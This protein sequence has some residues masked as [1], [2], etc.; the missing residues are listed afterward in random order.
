MFEACVFFS[1]F[2]SR[3]RVIGP[4][5]DYQLP[6][7]LSERC[8][9]L[10]HPDQTDCAPGEFVLY[11]M[12][13]AIRGHENPALD[14]AI[15]LA[16]QN[17]LPLVVYHGLSEKYPFASDRHHAFIMQAARDV[18]RELADLGITYAFH[19]ERAGH[20]GPHLRDLTRRA[21]VLV[22]EAM[23][24]APLVAWTERLKSLVS[25]PIVSVDTNCLLSIAQV[26]HL[27]AI[28]PSD[29][30][31][32]QHEWFCQASRY[33]QITQEQYRLR[34]GWDYGTLVGENP[35][36]DVQERATLRFDET[37]LGFEPVDLQNVCL[38]ELI[39][40]CK[41]DHTI[42][43]VT[44]SPG[45]MRTGYQRWEHFR[46]HLF[47]GYGRRHDDP[48]DFEGG[49]R[50]SAY[51]HYGM[52]SPFRI[53]RE[54]AELQENGEARTASAE[55]FLDEF[56]IWREMSFHFCQMC[57]DDLDSFDAIPVWAKETLRQHAVDSRETT[58]DW[59][60]LARA[61]TGHPLWDTAQRSLVKHGELHNHI[62]VNWGKAFLP[63]TT[64]PEQAL[65]H[66]IDLNHRYAL[67]GRSPASYGGILWCFGQFDEPHEEPGAI[68]GHV[69][70]RWIDSHDGQI[71]LPRFAQLV[72]RPIAKTL[73]RVAIVGAGIGGLM[74]ARAMQDHGLDVTV[75]DKS[76]GVGGRL[77][78]RRHA[79]APSF[80]HG[81]QYF[82][83][84]DDR[85]ARYVRSWI[86]AGVVE[87]WM[88][89]I[90]ELNR[91]RIMD[92]KQGTPRYV[93]KPA[94]NSIA[95]HLAKD[96][97]VTSG[98]TVGSLHHVEAT[99]AWQLS[100]AEDDELG[101]FDVVIMNCPP[102]QASAL[103]NSHT[104][105]VH[106]IDRVEMSPCWSL[107]LSCDGVC[108]LSF[109]GAFVNEG[110]LS[111]IA[112]NDAKP[113]RK[114]HVDPNRSDWVLHASVDWTNEHL[115]TPADE[116]SEAL[117]AAFET[118]VGRKLGAIHHR[119]AHRWLYAN[120]SH[121]LPQSCLWDRTTMLGA[122]GDWCGGPRVE[123]AFL[124]GAAI[125][126]CVLRHVTVDRCPA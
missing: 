117:T 26:T 27:A 8:Q 123:G 119:V 103:L 22:T 64:C 61:R 83:V 43:P 75:F 7:R 9:W 109:A 4:T 65:N 19:L 38:S 81:A 59:E 89:P 84:R 49:S 106:Q 52:V 76:R 15:A 36:E 124:S 62:R 42:A 48:S 69:R 126:G 57:C 80:D 105:L 73:P 24:V 23:P 88:S 72:D 58:F 86:A 71:D 44:D 53:A 47:V 92:H 112:R 56:L 98:C 68:Y 37:E 122:C 5:L 85:F 82:T 55:K 3:H 60:S 108:D 97:S 95:K 25:T 87:A 18:Q 125:A 96:I 120:T 41:I 110:P 66:C 93:G 74:A 45:G 10:I 107:M 39:G 35:A 21:G 51:L 70:P 91:G 90:V 34:A 2:P 14:V 100:S 54:A 1:E 12:H 28:D 101:T 104:D 29:R 6:A 113:G 40:Q 16:R 94:M 50:L 17:G 118:A 32:P 11:W 102:K 114:S 31:N 33:R 46:D 116:V 30:P 99:D 20:R 121:P 13:N 111:W 63:L 78:T 67:D 115:E 77:A 79:D